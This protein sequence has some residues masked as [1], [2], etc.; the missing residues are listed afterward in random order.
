[1]PLLAQL[2][3]SFKDLK[4]PCQNASQG[5]HNVPQKSDN[6]N[7][8]HFSKLVDVSINGSEINGHNG[9]QESRLQ[10]NHNKV[11][12]ISNKFDAVSSDER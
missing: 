3:S 12:K 4:V 11:S 6:D 2:V 9:K 10:S 8:L 7:D 1:M 5:D